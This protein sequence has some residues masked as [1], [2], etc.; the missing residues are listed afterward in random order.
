MKDM[1]ICCEKYGIRYN[2]SVESLKENE[3]ELECDKTCLK[4]EHHRIVWVDG[5]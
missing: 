4:C 2:P 5:E 1:Y 3:K